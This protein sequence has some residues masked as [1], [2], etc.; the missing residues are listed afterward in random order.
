MQYAATLA[1]G[2]SHLGVSEFM[3]NE[4][5]LV[6]EEVTSEMENRPKWKVSSVHFHHSEGSRSY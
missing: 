1:L 2:H 3:F 6:L 4:L 5:G